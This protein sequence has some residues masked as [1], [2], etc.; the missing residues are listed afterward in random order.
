[1]SETGEIVA[2]PLDEA[3]NMSV[4]IDT[5]TVWLTQRQMALL[6]GCDRVN[7]TQHL[8]NIFKSGELD[9]KVVCKDFLHTTQHGALNA[10]TQTRDVAH[11]NL[12]AVISVGYRVNSK[13]GIAFRRWA[14]GVLKERL[15]RDYV[16]RGRVA[17]PSADSPMPERV[18]GVLAANIRRVCGRGDLADVAVFVQSDALEAWLKPLGCGIREVRKMGETGALDFVVPRIR[19]FPSSNRSPLRTSGLYCAGSLGVKEAVENGKGCVTYIIGRDYVTGGEQYVEVCPRSYGVR[20]RP[21]RASIAFHEA[22]VAQI[23]RVPLINGGR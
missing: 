21:S 10:K 23:C 19:R 13:R 22:V 16:P 3:T 5:E 4:K 7:I 14:T 1:M 11:Y 18:R 2:Y 20:T 6:F 12:D 9:R 17:E 8:K 15:L